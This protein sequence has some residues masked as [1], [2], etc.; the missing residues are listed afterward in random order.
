LQLSN[1][2][3]QSSSSGTRGIQLSV[4]T[5]G[6][7]SIVL[8]FLQR[9]S[10]ESS[11]WA[12]IDYSTDGST[13]NIGFWINA[14]SL[15]PDGQWQSYSVNF[16]SVSAAENNPNFKVRIV[17][18]FS[19]YAFDQSN[20]TSTYAANTAYMIAANSAV[21]SPSYSNNSRNYSTSGAWRF[22]NISFVAQAIP[23]WANTQLASPM[24][25][26]YGTPSLGVAYS[27]GLTNSSV[28]ITVTPVSG[29]EISTQAPTGYSSNPLTNL[30]NGTTIYVRTIYNKPAGSFDQSNCFE[31]ASI[32]APTTLVSSSASNNFVSLTY[33]SQNDIAIELDQAYMPQG[34]LELFDQSGR[35][36]SYKQ[37]ELHHEHLPAPMVSGYYLLRATMQGQVNTQSIIINR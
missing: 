10:S 18:I 17:S 27:L 8:N 30:A 28:P 15:S 13:W 3:N 7:T 29:F 23:V 22:D 11:R 16:G 36:V 19:P 4:N 33:D 31:L 2:A 1:F 9:A 35:L 14:G 6:Y 21:F 20:Q 26:T 25:S 32:G 37:I 12:R 5:T 34:L 24:I